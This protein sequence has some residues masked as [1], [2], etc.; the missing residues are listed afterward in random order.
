VISE[1]KIR[2]IDIDDEAVSKLANS[3]KP[4]EGE[5]IAPFSMEWEAESDWEPDDPTAVS[6]GQCILIPYQI[7]PSHGQIIRSVGYAEAEQGITAY[8]FSSDG[9]RVLRASYGQSIAAERIWFASDHVRC[10][11]S[12]LKTSEGSGILQTSFASEVRKI[13]KP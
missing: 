7:D 8:S 5:L 10:R 4:L 13:S 2:C 6:S 11:S 1:V 3:V 9:A 12:G